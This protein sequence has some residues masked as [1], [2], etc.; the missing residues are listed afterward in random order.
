[1]KIGKKTKSTT[2]KP[3]VRFEGF[4]RETWKWIK[5]NWKTHPVDTASL[6]IATHPIY[7]AFEVNAG[8]ILGWIPYLG[9]RDMSDDLSLAVRKEISLWSIGGLS[10]AYA[11]LINRSRKK[12]GIT[13]NSPEK[14][15]TRHDAVFSVKFATATAPILYAVNGADLGEIAAGTIICAALAV[16]VGPIM[17]Y[18]IG[19]GRDLTGLE[20]FERKTYLDLIR[21]RN[22]YIKKGIA[23]AIVGAS[24]GMMGMIYSMTD[25]KF[26]ENQQ[27][28]VRQVSDISNVVD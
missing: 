11:N 26:G 8:K 3:G 15:Q 24:I 14:D 10:F 4:K 13:D 23:A 7:V 22:P 21:K 25:S 12:R 5:N 2:K 9:A 27:P 28:A 20:E 1:M 19:V 6:L 18:A 17:K 16:P